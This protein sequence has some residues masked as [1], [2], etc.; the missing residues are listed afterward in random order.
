MTWKWPHAFYEVI[1]ERALR[2]NEF[3][4]AGISSTNVNVTRYWSRLTTSLRAVS[5]LQIVKLVH[6]QVNCFLKNLRNLWGC[7]Q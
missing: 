6:A 1:K 5:D 4:R 7:M 2:I 3:N